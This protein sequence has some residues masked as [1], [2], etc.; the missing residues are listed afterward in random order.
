MK[1]PISITGALSGTMQRE[2]HGLTEREGSI[3]CPCAFFGL[4]ES[5]AGWIMMVGEVKGINPA[6]RNLTFTDAKVPTHFR[7]PKS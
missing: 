5:T 6:M 7:F 2:C 4:F 3:A 1:D